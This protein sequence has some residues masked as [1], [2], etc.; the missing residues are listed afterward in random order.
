VRPG[1]RW[2]ATVGVVVGAGLFFGACTTVEVADAPAVPIGADGSTDAELVAG[3]AVWIASCARCHGAA[4]GGGAGPRLTGD[5]IVERFP[6]DAALVALVASGR[7]GM[8]AFSGRLEP[9][10]IEAVAAYVRTL[11]ASS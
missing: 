7:G 9:E 6:T 10:E 8:P 4:G 5:R 2:A 3:R 1:R 11:I